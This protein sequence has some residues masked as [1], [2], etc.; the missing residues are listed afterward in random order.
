MTRVSSPV[1]ARPLSFAVLRKLGNH[2][3]DSRNW[4]GL[5]LSVLLLK[6]TDNL[7]G[8]LLIVSTSICPPYCPV[9]LPV[10]RCTHKRM[11]QQAWGPATLRGQTGGSQVQGQHEELSKV[12]LKSK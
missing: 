9:L 2:K 1:E 6:E 3:G 10:H 8:K 7:H 5:D 12:L 11:T 4:Q